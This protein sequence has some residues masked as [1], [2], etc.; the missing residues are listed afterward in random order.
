[1]QYSR[2]LLFISFLVTFGKFE[3]LSAQ[4]K[5]PDIRT[6]LDELGVEP[7]VMVGEFM[8]T[9]TFK[10]IPKALESSGTFEFKKGEL[11][12]NQRAPFPSS[13]RYQDGKLTQSVNG[14][15]ATDV[16]DQAT[17]FYGVISC[18][19]HPNEKCVAEHFSVTNVAVTK[20][21]TWT[22]T[23][24]PRSEMLRRAITSIALNGQASDVQ[25]VW[26]KQNDSETT[27]QF[28]KIKKKF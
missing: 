16:A 18:V 19:I 25:K 1:M 24:V 4:S 26:L 22:V 13:L 12:W 2:I 5:A 6:L 17:S 10:D 15:P 27:V 23:L 8:Q 3:T 21:H 28:S 7:E 9:K 20:G 11:S 14:Q